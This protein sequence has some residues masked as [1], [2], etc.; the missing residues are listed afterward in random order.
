MRHVGINPEKE[1]AGIPRTPNASRVRTHW[2]SRSVWSAAHSAAFVF[3]YQLVVG[4]TAAAC[5]HLA[6]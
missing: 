6:R 4:C 5:K 3:D 2:K 1:S